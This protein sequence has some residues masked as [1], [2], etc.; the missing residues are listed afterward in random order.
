MYSNK[1]CHCKDSTFQLKIMYLIK[2][3]SVFMESEDPSLQSRTSQFVLDVLMQ[4]LNCVQGQNCGSS[5]KKSTFARTTTMITTWMQSL[6]SRTL[7]VR[8]LFF[9]PPSVPASPTCLLDSGIVTKLLMKREN[10][11]YCQQNHFPTLF[12]FANLDVSTPQSA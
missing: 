5:T 12:D 11:D 10:C 3:S 6:S 8:L 4:V 9:P 1:Q 7:Y 2:K